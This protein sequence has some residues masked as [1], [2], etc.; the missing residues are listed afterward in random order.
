MD[1]ILDGNEIKRLV[2]VFNKKTI[3]F[4]DFCLL[5]NVRK[6]C[7]EFQEYIETK[8]IIGEIE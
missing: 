5:L 7:N 3:R 1:E 6:L 8:P 2:V 4:H